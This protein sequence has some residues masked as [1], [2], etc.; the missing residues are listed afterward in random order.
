MEI[1]KGRL[2]NGVDEV[3]LVEYV[4]ENCTNAVFL[5]F[6][7]TFL[8]WEVQEHDVSGLLLFSPVDLPHRWDRCRFWRHGN[9]VL[10]RDGAQLLHGV[11]PQVGLLRP[12]VGLLRPQV[13]LEPGERQYL[14]L[15]NVGR[16]NTCEKRVQQVGEG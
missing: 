14:V 6:R 7:C 13:G 1:L 15:V 2:L 8:E 4:N 16:Q 3:Q 9:E 5:T 11:R 10:L 12:Q